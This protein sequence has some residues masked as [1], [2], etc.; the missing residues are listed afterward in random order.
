MNRNKYN[1]LYFLKVGYIYVA[2]NPTIIETILGSC[3][4]V[5]LYDIKKNY[6]GMNHF[7]FP[8][9]HGVMHRN[10][11]YGDVAMTDLYNVFK[12]RGS[13][14][15][16]LRARIIG[17]AS[18]SGIDMAEKVA[19]K[20]IVV[21][22]NFLDL[23]NIRV[24]SENIGGCCGRIVLFDSNTNEVGLKKIGPLAECQQ[25]DEQIEVLSKGYDDE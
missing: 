5:C 21:A 12:K 8:H 13:R 1:A 7:I 25:I 10:N 16:D 24:I 22:K 17:G 6:G 11:K 15:Q 14:I 18:S 3:I 20:N 23:H 2:S 9:S 4:S 19:K